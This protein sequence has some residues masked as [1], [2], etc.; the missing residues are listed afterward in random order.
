V[1][2]RF[3]TTALQDNAGIWMVDDVQEGGRERLRKLLELGHQ[4]MRI[5]MQVRGPSSK[6]VAKSSRLTCAIDGAR[7]RKAFNPVN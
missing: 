5:K 3:L 4:L 1:P 2:A 6:G 7:V